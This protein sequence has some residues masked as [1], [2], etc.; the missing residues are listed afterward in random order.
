MPQHLVAHRHPRQVVVGVAD[1]GELPVEHRR[2]PARLVEEVARPGVAVAQRRPRRRGGRVAASHSRAKTAA[3]L[4][5]RV[6]N[7]GLDRAATAEMSTSAWAG[8]S[9]GTSS[10]PSVEV[11]GV[12][13]VQPAELVQVVV[14]D[15]DRLVGAR[16]ST[17]RPYPPRRSSRMAL[18]SGATPSRAGHRAG[19]GRSRAR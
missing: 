8:P 4:D 5:P 17:G 9:S 10:A 19:R 11:A 14:A 13:Q 1:V 18:P 3:G 16:A 7:R 15:R 6:G 2:D 12:E